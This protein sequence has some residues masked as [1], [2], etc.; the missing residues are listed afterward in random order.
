MP[1]D[2]TFISN[3]NSAQPSVSAPRVPAHEVI[4]VF[5]ELS[6]RAPVASANVELPVAIELGRVRVRLTD[7]LQMSEGSVLEL[8]KLAGDPVDVV[9]N[10]RV[11]A[12]GEVVVLNQKFAV[13]VSQ[14]LPAAKDL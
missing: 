10:D 8:D 14:V 7:L 3:S 9:V 11:V 12:R 6:A 1:D 4:P 5:R 13:R 2:S